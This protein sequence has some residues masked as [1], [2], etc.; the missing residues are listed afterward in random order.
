MSEERGGES[1][2]TL[3]SFAQLTFA[4]LRMNALSS[5]GK[6]QDVLVDFL[7]A[8]QRDIPSSRDAITFR[9]CFK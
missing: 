1:D 9:P 4:D 5:V 3:N 8:G 7:I 2:E 6:C